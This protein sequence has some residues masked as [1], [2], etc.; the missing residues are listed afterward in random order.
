M[1]KK[2]AKIA[3]TYFITIIA[4]LAII[5]GA[6]YFLLTSYLNGSSVDESAIKPS[7]SEE[8]PSVLSEDYEPS[9]A[10]G[11]TLLAV[12][13]PEKRSTAACF[14]LAR[15]V[16]T[17][18][19]V[20]IVP[21]Q[22]DIC[23]TLDGKSNTL[24]EFY[25]LGG[26]PDAKRA[27]EQSTGIKIDKYIKF[28]ES[29]F[30]TFS[31]FM[32]NVNYDVPYN[33]IYENESTGESTII[34]SGDQTLDSTSLRK[35]LT[36]PNFKGGEEYRAKVVGALAADLINSGSKGILKDALDTVFTDVINSDIETDIT[37]YDYDEKKAAIQYVLNNSDSPAQLVIPSG[38]YNEN[39]CYVLD[40]TFIQALPR[41][42]YME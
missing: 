12:Y 2:S 4:A 17:E 25:R 8:A 24:Y 14:V 26:I 19:K 27:A 15:F 20:V 39:N 29:S 28:T 10:D 42:F 38:T 7:S 13:E 31:N 5:G 22:T 18:N 16:P 32:G 40:E 36:F 21:L 30:V 11:Q 3:A 35:I 33:L 6:G 37:R 34:K 9:E 23:T 1:S 41:W